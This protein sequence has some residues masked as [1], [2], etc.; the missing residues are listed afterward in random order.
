MRFKVITWIPDKQT[1]IPIGVILQDE[2]TDTVCRVKLAPV[3]GEENIG[4]WEYIWNDQ[5]SDDLNYYPP[6]ESLHDDGRRVHINTDTKP[7]SFHNMEPV[8]RIHPTD[9]KVC[10]VLFPQSQTTVIPRFD[11]SENW[12]YI[13]NK[14][15]NFEDALRQTF[16]HYV[17]EKK[18]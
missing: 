2:E 8:K 10:H 4:A 5:L 11:V 16:V 9:E 15:I 17:Q 18:R 12:I 7:F 13:E 14:F 6:G 1:V 3:A